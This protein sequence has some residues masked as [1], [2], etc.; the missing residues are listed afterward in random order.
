MVTAVTEAVA[1]EVVEVSVGETAEAM[2]EVA[3]DL[4]AVT[5]W[6]EGWLKPFFLFV[7]FALCT[8]YMQDDTRK[9]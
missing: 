9:M 5:K 2:E 4:E 1:S 8:F 3:E 7:C 6:E